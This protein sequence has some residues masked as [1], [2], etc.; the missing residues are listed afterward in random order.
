M[1]PSAGEINDAAAMDCTNRPGAI[2]WE[3]HDVCSR[4]KEIAYG[5]GQCGVG[6]KARK[7]Q[8][9]RSALNSNVPEFKH[10]QIVLLSCRRSES[11]VVRGARRLRSRLA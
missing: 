5:M 2:V 1:D 11:R 3:L 6:T 7:H 8:L 4:S 10:K 9:G